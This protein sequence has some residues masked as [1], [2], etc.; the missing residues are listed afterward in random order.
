MKKLK[1]ILI[2]ILILL[3]ALFITFIIFI[4]ILTY[5]YSSTEQRIYNNGIH[6]DCG[7]TWELVSVYEDDN[8]YYSCDKCGKVIHVYDT[9]NLQKV[10]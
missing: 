1:K 4:F 2:D 5:I 9:N 8:Y 6:E 3:P 10:H 7:G